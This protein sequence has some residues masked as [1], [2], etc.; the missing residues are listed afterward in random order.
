[1]S[2][3]ALKMDDKPSTIETVGALAKSYAVI[4]PTPA[5]A[6]A[7]W[8]GL[9]LLLITGAVDKQAKEGELAELR[10]FLN[11]QSEMIDMHTDATRAARR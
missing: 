7:A 6:T 5:S 8:S 4:G 9:Y 1:M 2:K 3:P 10:E 11:T